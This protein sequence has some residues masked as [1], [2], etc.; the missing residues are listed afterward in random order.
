[1]C[2]KRVF[3]CNYCNFKFRFPDA[4]LGKSLWI[5]NKV[6]VVYLATAEGTLDGLQ[7]T[8]AYWSWLVPREIIILLINLTSWK[9]REIMR[10]YQSTSST[11]ECRWND[12]PE[13]SNH[14]RIMSK[15]RLRC[16][17]FSNIRRTDGEMGEIKI[18][19]NISM[20]SWLFMGN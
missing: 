13:K 18:K 3:S 5:T 20:L 11:T 19:R 10:H 2:W 7:W 14:Y 1:M 6:T 12:F 8:Y 9:S 15:A 4:R 17:C 16:I